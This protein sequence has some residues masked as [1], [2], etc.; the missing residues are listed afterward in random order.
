MCAAQSISP[1][2]GLRSRPK[3]TVMDVRS[4]GEADD[5]DDLLCADGVEEVTSGFCLDPA[6]LCRDHCDLLLDAID[7]QLSRLQTHSHGRPNGGNGKTENVLHSVHLRSSKSM[8]KDSVLSTTPPPTG[9]TTSTPNESNSDL[10]DTSTEVTINIVERGGQQERG[11]DRVRLFTAP[12]WQTLGAA[13]PG[14]SKTEQCLWRLERLL[15]TTIGVTGE[16]EEEDEEEEESVCTEDFSSRFRDVMLDVPVPRSTG[17]AW[18]G[19]NGSCDEGQTLRSD[20]HTL[21]TQRDVCVTDTRTLR[22]N[23][24]ALQ[25][26]TTTSYHDVSPHRTTRYYDTSPPS[27]GCYHNDS[28]HRCVTSRCVSELERE[29]MDRLVDSAKSEL[30]SEQRRFRHTL[31]SLQ[32]R[33]EEVTQD[34]E[35]K[36]EVNRKLRERCSRLEEELSTASKH[37]EEPQEVDLDRRVRALETTVAQKELLVLVMQEEKNSLEKKIRA[38]QEEHSAKLTEELTHMQKKQEQ[39]IERLQV[40]WTQARERDME[41]VHRQ[42]HEATAAALRDQTLTHTRNTDSLHNCIQIKEQEVSRLQESLEQQQELLRRQEEELKLKT[43]EQVTMAVEQEQRKW[44]RQRAESLREQRGILEE[45]VQEVERRRRAEVE[46]ERRCALSL[47]N[48]ALELQKHVDELKRALW[49]EQQKAESTTVLLN[50]SLKQS[51][52]EIRDLRAVL[53]ESERVHKGAA[54]RQEQQS[55]SWAQDILMECVW[56]QEL[57]TANGMP[58]H[59]KPLP[60]RKRAATGVDFDDEDDA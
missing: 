45:R 21:Q 11:S 36:E 33:L 23:Q 35:Q 6:A 44:E 25:K 18:E 9:N 17:T 2:A 30:F 3:P 41:L 13:G 48:K 7:D 10:P 40:Q 16:E 57:L 32:E 34:L 55:R 1:A 27:T 24:A 15:G 51:E 22:D 12:S 60:P 5:T 54:G 46:C 58:A 59:T 20:Q 26:H 42:A 50:Q 39:D 52:W 53:A 28:H 4:H 14:G 47:Q 29:E 43:E 8:I 56:L 49:D 31:E 19:Q 37:R 38:L